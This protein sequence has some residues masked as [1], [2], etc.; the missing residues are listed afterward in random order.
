MSGETQTRT[1]SVFKRGHPRT[2]P[3]VVNN[4]KNIVQNKKRNT[5]A[6]FVPDLAMDSLL[7]KFTHLAVG[8]VDI[9]QLIVIWR[10]A[11]YH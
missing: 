1:P 9:L 4:S 3:N 11:L 8:V 2:S 7:V 6:R 5:C 10:V